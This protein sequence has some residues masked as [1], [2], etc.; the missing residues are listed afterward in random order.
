MLWLNSNTTENWEVGW[1]KDNLNYTE[2]DFHLKLSVIVNK[3]N[4]YFKTLR[5]IAMIF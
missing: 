1:I 5:F 3:R 2:Q 4:G